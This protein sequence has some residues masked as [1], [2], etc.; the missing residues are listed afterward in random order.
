MDV[1]K[2]LLIPI[3]YMNCATW[4]KRKID[5]LKNWDHNFLLPCCGRLN[6]VYINPFVLTLDKDKLFDLSSGGKIIKSI[7]SKSLFLNADG[8]KKTTSFFKEWLLSN[9]RKFNAPV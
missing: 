4:T 7:A 5:Q 9:I 8:H 2:R 6:Y 3:P 1:Q